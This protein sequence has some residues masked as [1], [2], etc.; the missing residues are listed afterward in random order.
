[1]QAIS[2]SNADMDAPED[3]SKSNTPHPGQ[4]GLISKIKVCQP[5]KPSSLQELKV[6]VAT[7]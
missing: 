7:K 1:M 6:D 3:K 2:K 5:L 4:V